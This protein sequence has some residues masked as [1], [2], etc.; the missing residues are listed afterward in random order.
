M[1]HGLVTEETVV[2]KRIVPYATYETKN[3]ALI[4][5]GELDEDND[6]QVAIED[7]WFD[8]DACR[9]ASKIFADLA[10]ALEQSVEDA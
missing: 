5:I 4:V 8:A 3:G 7:Y 10:D 2:R 9:D 6:V 1:K